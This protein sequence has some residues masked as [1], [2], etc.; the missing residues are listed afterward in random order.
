M[1]VMYSFNIMANDKNYANNVKISMSTDNNYVYPTIVS[2]TSIMENSSKNNKYEFYILFSGNISKKSKEN[3]LSLSKKYGNCS[4]KTINM[5]NAFKNAFVSRHITPAAY[6]RLSLPSILKDI[7]K[8]LYMDVDTITE[9]DLSDLYNTNIDKYY[10]AGVKNPK[11]V[12]FG[13]NYSNMLK[14]KS[15]S[16]YINSGVMLLN[17]KAMRE[18]NIEKKFNNT[19]SKNKFPF[20]DQDVIN[21][22]CYN[23][24]YHL[25]FKYNMMIHYD[26]Y[27]NY[28]Y[29]TKLISRCF[30]KSDWDEG[31]KHP[32]IIHYHIPSKPWLNKNTRLANKWWKYANK[33]GFIKEIKL[34]YHM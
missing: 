29:K 34:K 33:S 7:D 3:I 21:S 16:Q 15:M 27:N 18:H 20:H 28:A 25:P 13:K 2:M 9:K 30:S 24:I 5:K 22:V 11:F 32:V 8:V 23:K 26:I 1:S 6:Y 4:I 17:L 12:A 31:R 10:L 19:L 14:I